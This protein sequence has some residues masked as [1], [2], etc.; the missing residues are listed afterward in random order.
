[1]NLNYVQKED[2]PVLM[3]MF[4][5][6]LGKGY[7]TEEQIL[8]HITDEKELFY[9]SRK[10]DGT[11]CG[12]LLFGEEPAEVLAEQT[13]I[14]LPELLRMAGGKP[15]LKCRSMCI[16]KEFQKNGVGKELFQKALADIKSK[17][18][19]GLI[20]SLLWEYQGNVPAE[21]LHID[22]GFQF[23]HRLK[24]PWYGYKDYTCIICK[25][26]CRCDGLQYVLKLS[27]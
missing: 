16:S 9:A 4:D 13:K 8:H 24:M 23:L 20:T 21:K 25:G 2:I 11:L 27:D 14:P 18:R 1:M 5:E 12:I 7:M 17:K 26:R 6:N 15:L 10:D 22:N 3:R 19:Y